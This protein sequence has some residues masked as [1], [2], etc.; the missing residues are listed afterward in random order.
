VAPCGRPSRETARTR[1][2]YQYLPR[3]TGARFQ[4]TEYVRVSIAHSARVSGMSGKLAG[5]SEDPGKPSRGG[6]SLA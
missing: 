2:L 6:I 5:G 1:V 4:G 3:R